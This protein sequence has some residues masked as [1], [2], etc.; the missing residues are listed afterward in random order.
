[1]GLGERVRLARTFSAPRRNLLTPRHQVLPFEK[2]H[3]GEGAIASDLCALLNGRADFVA[4]LGPRTVVV[5]HIV[6]P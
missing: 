4:P 1:M 5:A 2:V 3:D 6:Q